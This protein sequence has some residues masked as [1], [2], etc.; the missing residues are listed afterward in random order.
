MSI[1]SKLGLLFSNKFLAEEIAAFK[2][3]GDTLSDASMLKRSGEGREFFPG[4]DNRGLSSFN[5]FYSKYI[6]Y[7]FDNEVRKMRDYRSIADMPEVADV[8]EDAVI[9]CAQEDLEGDILKLVVKD[10]EIEKNENVI[11]KLRDEFDDLFNNKIKIKEC[12]NELLRS[13][14]IDGRVYYERLIDESNKTEGIVG[15]KKLP[16]ETMDFEYD[17]TTGKMV[18]FI[19]YLIPNP[20]TRPTDLKAAEKAGELVLFNPNQIGLID[21]GVYGSLRNEIFGYLEKVKVPFNQLKLLETSVVIYRLIRAPERLVFKID[22][23]NMPREKAMK[24]LE[25]VK[26]G[27]VKK[28]SYDPSTGQL[29]GEIDPLA[30]LDNYF[31]AVGGEGGRGSEVTT[32]GGSSTAGFTELNDIHYFQRKLYRALKYPMSR[33]TASEDRQENTIV[34]NNSPIGT[35][36]RDEVKWAVWLERQQLKFCNEFKNLFL[37]HLEFKGL[38]AEWEIVKD[39]FDIAMTPP[40]YFREKEQ[41]L[42]LETRHNNYNALAIREEFSKSYLMKKYLEWDE[43]EIQENAAGLKEDLKIGLTKEEPEGGGKF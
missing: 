15:L 23:G 8:V 42:L 2:N 35:I 36:A 4:F 10:E 34:F 32:I 33:I 37:L 38:K 25:K 14:F 20:L 22:V 16:N 19:Q 6:N 5:L 30:I 21:Y 13:Y 12:I 26:T 24:Y 9:E 18:R 40:S 27:M 43:D 31:L 7:K 17:Y 29:T 28:Q 41:Q 1:K 3:K 39:S 11:T